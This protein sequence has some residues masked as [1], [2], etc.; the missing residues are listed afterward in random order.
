MVWNVLGKKRLY[1][2]MFLILQCSWSFINRLSYMQV[3]LK[4]CLQ[5][6]L[7]K[8]SYLNFLIFKLGFQNCCSYLLHYYNIN[9]FYYNI[10]CEFMDSVPIFKTD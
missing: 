7:G 6:K 3:L 2:S 5:K 8:V 1:F 9:L 4:E 10:T